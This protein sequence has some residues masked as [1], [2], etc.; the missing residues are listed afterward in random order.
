MVDGYDLKLQPQ[1]FTLVAGIAAW[2]SRSGEAGMRIYFGSQLLGVAICYRAHKYH[3]GDI[4]TSAG[5]GDRSRACSEGGNRDGTGEQSVCTLAAQSGRQLMR[6]APG[7]G[8]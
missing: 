1:T 3:R 7:E 8:A 2:R 4:M 6:G 5:P